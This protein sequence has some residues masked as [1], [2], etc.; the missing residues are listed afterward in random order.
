MP[1]ENNLA[2]VDGRGCMSRSFQ[3][4]GTLSTYTLE[5]SDWAAAQKPTDPAI[6]SARSTHFQMPEETN[7][8]YSANGLA[9]RL[10]LSLSLSLSLLLFACLS[11]S[12]QER[13]VRAIG[14]YR[15][16][17]STPKTAPGA[18]QPTPPGRFLGFFFT[19]GQ[20]LPKKLPITL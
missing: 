20:S 4:G 2:Q 11:S 3:H 17:H 13:F 16:L 10:S 12:T 1:S 18:F 5:Y 8:K 6:P 14:V 7:H 15:Y 19:S 9:L